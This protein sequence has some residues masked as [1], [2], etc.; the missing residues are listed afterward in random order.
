MLREQGGEAGMSPFDL[1]EEHGIGR[2]H[3]VDEGVRPRSDDSEVVAGLGAVP[4]G[5][6]RLPLDV[7]E[8]ALKDAA[9]A[10]TTVAC[11]LARH[12][13]GSRP[14]R[15]GQLRR[16]LSLQDASRHVLERSTS[17]DLSE[18]PSGG[19]AVVRQN[20]EVIGELGKAFR[21]LHEL[22][23]R[24]V[25]V[26]KGPESCRVTRAESVG[27]DVVVEEVDVDGGHTAVEIG[28]HAEGE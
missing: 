26:V 24:I 18:G 4:L 16:A 27:E 23:H 7:I 1:L 10:G 13:N 12:A 28:G 5:A 25:D 6:V 14:A 8:E 22:A 9:G 2:V 21:D 15:R 17:R 11:E 3:E 19:L 20:V